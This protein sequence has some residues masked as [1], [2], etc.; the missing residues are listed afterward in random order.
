MNELRNQVNECEEKAK[1]PSNK[2]LNFVSLDEA[3]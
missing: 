1:K 3:I 2:S